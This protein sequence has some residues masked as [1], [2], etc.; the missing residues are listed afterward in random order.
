MDNNKKKLLKKI[1]V[2]FICSVVISG[3]LIWIYSIDIVNLF[4]KQFFYANTTE[5]TFNVNDLK[6]EGYKSEESTHEFVV[7]NNDPKFELSLEQCRVSSIRIDF[8]KELEEDIAIQVY[9]SRLDSYYSED[10][11]VKYLLPAN[12]KTCTLDI[13]ESDITNIRIDIGE[14]EGEKFLLDKIV[15]NESDDSVT[16]ID[17]I[18]S[19]SKSIEIGRF[20]CQWQLI[21]LV[22]LFVGMHFITDIK[23]LYKN[24]F[25]YRWV[26]AGLLLLFLVGNKFHGE[27]LAI[28]DSVIQ[29]GAGSEYVQPIFGKERLI[30]SD[31]YVVETPSKLASIHDG[32]YGKYNEIARGTE[33]L[34]AI[35]GVYIGYSTI[36]RS[37]FQFVYKIL[38]SEYAYSFCWYAPII[39]CFLV[40]IEFFLIISR[41]NSLVS[42]LGA[43]L[44]VLS[45]FYLWW[46]F[47]SFLLGAQAAIVCAFY[48]VKTK[49]IKKKILFG[50]GVAVSFA[51]YVLCLY[52]AWIV[53]MGYVALCFVV[54]IIH[55]KWNDIKVWEKKDWLILGAMAIFSLSI[56]VSYFYVNQEYIYAITHTLYPGKRVSNGGFSLSKIFLYSQSYLYA[57]KDIENASE[58]SVLLNFFPIPTIVV[59]VS[60]IKEKKKDWLTGSLLGVTIGF[61]VYTTV[62]LPEIISKVTLLGYTTDKRLID[63]LA[64]IQVYFIVIILSN[65]NKYVL[66]NFAGIG[67]SILTTVLSVGSSIINYEGYLS[68]KWMLISG[69]III[70]VGIVLTTKLGKKYQ[71]KMCIGLICISVMSSV[72][73][74]PISKGFDAVT[75]KPVSKEIQK[76]VSED[77]DSKWIAYGGGIYLPGFAV[78][79]GASTINS[80]NTYPNL[81]LWEK[82]DE[83]GEYE[84]VYNR[85]MH[86]MIEFT[87]EET[88]FELLYPD[89]MKVNLSYKDIEKTEVGYVLSVEKLDIVN[90][91][92]KF[93]EIYNEQGAYIYKINYM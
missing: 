85:Y 49:E 55:E 13:F 40:A 9:Y 83:Q 41:N 8:E 72:G 2:V 38:P 64:I 21:F 12:S 84:E 87:D 62:G 35:N 78:A 65:P 43:C 61:I 15:I 67:I 25:K 48:F 77:S 51:N 56:I 90:D 80:T 10:N 91:H 23:N 5:S 27:S 68:W 50:V 75:S 93:E 66:S 37:P 32:E 3:I 28:Y 20:I 71:S 60:W 18:V 57:F 34:N 82:L 26:I 7:D 59:L 1:I 24:M 39:L 63:V 89:Q 73:I 70:S 86:I 17:D 33:T 30:R 6:K 22:V 69:I 11:S 92:V 58:A 42:V 54:W 29:T 44:E 46:G 14:T 79:N 52:P 74:R 16:I 45:S 88:N 76:I 36:G 81:E 4:R 53:P 31:D 19:T 47:P